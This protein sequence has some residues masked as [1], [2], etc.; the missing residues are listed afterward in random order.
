[1]N[2]FEALIGVHKNT[3]ERFIKYKIS[4]RHDAE[5]IIQEVYL[6]GFRNF[7]TL[8]NGGSFKAWLLGIAYHKCNDYFRRKA[9]WV[10]IPLDEL[11]DSA[12]C[13]DF[14]DLREETVVR[15]TIR[16]LGEKDKQVLYLYYFENLPQEEIAKC[17][18][19]P[20]GTVKSRLYY[21][22][23]NCRENYPYPPKMKGEIV[24][25]KWPEMMPSYQIT[26]LDME[27]FTVKNEELPGMFIIP[28]RREECSFA[29]YDFPER[30]QSG[31][32]K[33]KVVGDVVIHGVRGVEI[34]SEYR[35]NDI[36]EKRTIFAQLTDTHCRYLGG[37]H[38]DRNG[39]RCVVT[40]LDDAFEDSYGIGEN[41]CGFPIEK[42]CAGLFR[43]T[44]DGLQVELKD[45]ICDI[46]G[47]YKINI[48]DKTYDTVRILDVQI[49]EDLGTMLCECYVDK[50]G[51][52]VL[53]RRFNKND[54][55]FNRYQKKWTEILPGNERLRINGETYVHWYDCITDYVL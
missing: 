44:K 41:N 46:C 9:D 34:E 52:T 51:R 49:T 45:D 11:A 6:A 3:L 20:V 40:F 37:I 7:A 2:D 36:V 47:R 25:K 31:V 21:A 16:R 54:W 30:K 27:P 26:K 10:D 38:T 39:A 4:N 35:E 33:L 48:G 50:T 42:S 1:M 22:K 43:E 13:S 14:Y 24:M 32:Y 17:L 15:E 55:A 8:K 5:D 19:I 28:K 23:K 29:L 18:Q 53:R 12:M